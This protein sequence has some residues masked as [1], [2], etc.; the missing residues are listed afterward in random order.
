MQVRKLTRLQAEAACSVLSAL[1]LDL[2]KLRAGL[3][4]HAE[5][6]DA[7]DGYADADTFV[8]V[9]N[10]VGAGYTAHIESA[11]DE[12]TGL[13]AHIAADATNVLT[14]P[15]ATDLTSA[16]TLANNIK[17][18]ANLHFAS[19]ACHAVAD[20]VSSITAS[21]ATNLATLQTLLLDIEDQLNSHMAAAFSAEPIELIAP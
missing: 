10:A 8:S 9:T 3:V 21:D 2:L 6:S 15:D 14:A 18:K 20:S 4:F 19:T 17:T 1:R 12:V 16:C 11:C 7:V 13:G 5:A